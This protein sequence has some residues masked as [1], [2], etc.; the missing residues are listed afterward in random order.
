MATTESQT[1]P[2]NQLLSGR[3]LSAAGD[4]VTAFKPSNGA[5]GKFI[6]AIPSSAD[7][8]RAAIYACRKA[9][10]DS[11]AYPVAVGLP[12][13]AWLLRE[14]GAELIALENVYAHSPELEGDSV[15]RREITARIAATSAQTTM[16]SRWWY[17]RDAIHSSRNRH[18][19]RTGL[20]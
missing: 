19:R 10:Q 20:E 9:S 11:G 17:R 13:N 14:L 18:D 5:T 1:I 16:K 15:A 8:P 3:T 4:A 12:R 2:T 6:L 7:Q